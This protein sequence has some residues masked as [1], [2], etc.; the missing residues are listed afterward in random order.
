MLMNN[1]TK[2]EQITSS[3][4]EVNVRDVVLS[5]LLSTCRTL[6]ISIA[7]TLVDALFAEQVKAARQRNVF[8]AILADRAAQHRESHLQHIR[9]LGTHPA[10]IGSC[11]FLFLCSF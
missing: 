3:I 9:I 1:L 2:R 5:E 7:Y 11:G 6:A 8:E 4:R 10:S